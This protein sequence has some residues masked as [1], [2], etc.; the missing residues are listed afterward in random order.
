M[1]FFP[2][3]ACSRQCLANRR[4]PHPCAPSSNPLG[5]A[6]HAA[7]LSMPERGFWPIENMRDDSPCI[8]LVTAVLHYITYLRAL[9][10]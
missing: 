2:G 1:H 6:C 7:A 9:N 8:C 10:K 4:P 3:Q 5:V